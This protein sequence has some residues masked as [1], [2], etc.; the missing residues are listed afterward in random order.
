LEPVWSALHP[1][2][3]QTFH[4]LFTILPPAWLIIKVSVFLTG[5][6]G[7]RDFFAAADHA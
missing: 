5:P 1:V 7:A 6:D 2:L 3:L 4:N